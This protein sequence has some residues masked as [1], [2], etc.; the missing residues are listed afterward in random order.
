MIAAHHAYNGPVVVA[1]CGTAVTV[2]FVD[3]SGDFLGGVIAPG[4]EL[5][6][7]ALRRGTH[8]LPPVEQ[9]AGATLA[10]S[11]E[12]AIVSGCLAATVGLITIIVHEIKATTGHEPKCLLTGGDAPRIIPKLPLPCDHDP[13]LVLRGLAILA[14]D[15]S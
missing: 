10:L 8:A 15:A 4:L 9:A 6:H 3:A 7:T 11:T 14:N 5:M 13:D 2:D 12:A 1:D